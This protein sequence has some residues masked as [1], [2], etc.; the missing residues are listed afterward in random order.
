M[1]GLIRDMFQ[2][3]EAR[4]GRFF[5]RLPRDA[6]GKLAQAENKYAE[7]RVT[8][9][10]GGVFYIQFKGQRVKMLD[11]KPDVPGKM[12]KIL[13]DGDEMNYPSGDKVLVDV[14]GGSLSP[15][16]AKSHG[17]FWADTDRS[18]YDAEEFIQAFEQFLD[19]MRMVLGGK[20]W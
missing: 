9:P 4:Q 1:P 14:V 10:E 5:D 2:R 20:R 6:K 11:E 13:V 19:E 7:V 12:D 16:A 17:L 8:G 18:I 3:F 15:R